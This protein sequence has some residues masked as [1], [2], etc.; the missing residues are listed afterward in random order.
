M[1][2]DPGAEALFRSASVAGCRSVM[3]EE[4]DDNDSD[5]EKDCDDDR[6][7]AEFGINIPR[8]HN[9]LYLRFL[10]ITGWMQNRLLV[11]M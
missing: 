4:D 5:E 9:V 7:C 3:A 6:L 8:G 2:I 1:F 11:S 10:L